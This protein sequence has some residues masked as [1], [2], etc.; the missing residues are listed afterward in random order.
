[1]RR[2]LDLALRLSDPRDANLTVLAA[3]PGVISVQGPLTP[4]QRAELALGSGGFG[5]EDGDEYSYTFGR[6]EDA[7]RVIVVPA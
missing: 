6:G 1:M 4:G 7:I 2:T 3:A 5:V